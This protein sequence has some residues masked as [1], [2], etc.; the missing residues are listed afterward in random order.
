MVNLGSMGKDSL[1]GEGTIFTGARDGIEW[2]LK[3]SQRRRLEWRDN[4]EMP[5][6]ELEG[7]A[8]FQNRRQS[9]MK[10]QEKMERDGAEHGRLA[11]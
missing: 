4:T 1:Q 10:V 2:F 11:S 8:G 5:A 7:N 3:C 6:Q 9:A